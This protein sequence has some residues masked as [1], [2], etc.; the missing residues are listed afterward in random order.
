MRTHWQAAA[1]LAV[2]F[3]LGSCT[4]VNEATGK[5]EFTPFMSPSQE[6]TIGE[7]EHP[8]L[9]A[10]FG[11]RYA[12]PQLSNYVTEVGKRL[13]AR[14]EQ[15]DHPYTFTVLNSKVVNA[16][17][18]PGGYVHISRGLMVLFN[19][20]A[21]M[22][23]VLGHEIGHVTARHSAQRYNRTMFSQLG[24]VLLGAATGN[25]G[26][27]NLV[28]QGSQLALLSY[29]RKQEKQSDELGIRYMSRVGYDPY[30]SVDM[31][32]VLAAQGDFQAKL[33]GQSAQ[34]TANI[35][36]THPEPARRMASAR[37]HIQELGLAAGG[38]RGR[39][40]YLAA[41]DGML[42]GDD[43]NDGLVQGQQFVH[44]GLLLKFTA[45]DGIALTN[46][47]AAVYGTAKGVQVMFAG[48]KVA[49]GATTTSLL[50]DLWSK[51]TDGKG[52]TLQ[53]VQAVRTNGMTGHT[54]VGRVSGQD[55]S[56]DI[57]LVNW[58]FSRDRVYHFIFVTNAGSLERYDTAFLQMARSLER[59]PEAEAAA[60]KPQRVRI[61]TVRRGDTAT[62]LSNRMAMPE[63]KLD[64]FLFING[65]DDASSL[66]AG[67]K[68]KIIVE[69]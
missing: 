54:G 44:P 11:G 31:L 30:G 40:R 38:D 4:T 56:Y 63:N 18:L 37:A 25:Q 39:D 57:R 60:I 1:I 26:L 34:Q 22:A 19:D 49:E 10:Q 29:S 35:L 9:V 33:S 48:G 62:S 20:E 51:L 46:T 53:S 28:G 15:P 23:S 6:R 8:K 50:K 24:T 52:G 5:R 13:Q 43:P 68:V 59:M 55:A 32:G 16:F 69:G 67:Q 42:F 3:L 21:E 58:K 64:W 66:R 2:P 27:A 17:A 36:R 47:P 45:P 65:M 14:S 41:I 12:D 61:V 7:Q